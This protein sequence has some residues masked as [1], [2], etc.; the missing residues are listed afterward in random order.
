M[1]AGS[2]VV[3]LLMRT[4]SFET[5]TKRAAAR[6]KELERS[7][8]AAGA[9]IG[10]A[11][12]AAAAA[13]AAFVKSSINAADA[14]IKNA[15]SIGLTV[16]AYTALAF[17]A[18]L[19]GVSQE[20][21]GV[22]LTKLARTAS[23]AAGG[24]KT[25]S[26]AFAAMG[27]S[28][29]TASGAIKDT[30]TLLGEIANKFAS[31]ADGAEKT[32]L[33]IELFGRSGAKL[34][35]L[36]NQGAAGIDALKREAAELGI[37][38]D[39]QTAK[40]AEQFNDDL[41][42]L[43]AVV[44]GFGNA[45]MREAIG[46]L[47]A[48][49]GLLLDLAR[50]QATA[51]IATDIMRAAMGG[52]LVTFQA[53]VVLASDVAFVLR[54]IGR[55]IG[56]ITAQ[57]VALAKFDGFQ[58]YFL[59]KAMKEDAEAARAELDKF[60]ARVMAMGQQ[61]A[62]LTG[63]RLNAQTDPRSLAFG[64]SAPRAPTLPSGA[65]RSAG[66]S[67]A[68]K[69]AQYLEQL[70]K[71]LQGT[72]D[73]SVEEALLADIQ[74]GRLG[75]VLPAQEA[76]LRM[77][78]RQIDAAKATEDA[79]RAAMRTAQ[80]R[81]DARK[82]EDEQI[83]ESIRMA[84]EADAA[85]LK[86]LTSGAYSE[87]LKEVT[88]DVQFLNRAYADGK[89]SVELWAE[90][91]TEATGRLKQQSEEID[92][93]AKTMQENMQGFLGTAFADAMEGNFKNIGKSFTQMINRMVAEALAADLMRRL[94]GSAAKGGSGDGWIGTA[95]AWGASLFGG[96]KAGGGDAMPGRAYWVG[97][98]GPEMFVPRTA[99]TVLPAAQSAGAGQRALVV[100]NSFTVA[101]NVTRQT[102][103]QIGAEAARALAAASR[104]NN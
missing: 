80:E 52:L 50:D 32:A 88:A 67:A 21:M 48:L 84:Q 66:S 81:S 54:G 59:R 29:K 65:G 30:D 74:A 99:G 8:K 64:Q 95:V 98:Q 102:Q 20:E 76:E 78:A 16:E 63:A 35:P 75:K 17:A 91:V 86:A 92:S 58:F 15:Q 44:R 97:E 34:I 14:A 46:P 60:Q 100:N 11:F 49:N 10:T 43:G 55:E 27:V 4:G 33:A 28:V 104:R 38:M 12:V 68:D 57:A 37:V 26:A 51:S 1:A 36:L 24:S 23:D 40:A 18:D 90:A 94:F 87:Q 96:S 3:D 79:Y 47:N 72:K 73:L 103:A 93:F 22:A 31:Y 53:L 62:A 39:T 9:V 45:I 56:G 85:R 42:R 101:G 61:S 2:I 25:A 7:A 69:A 6:L 77:V 70:R 13:T 71:Q 83:A 41:T 5:D 82:R 89:I 19:S